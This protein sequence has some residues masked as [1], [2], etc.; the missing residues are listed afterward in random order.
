[1][2]IIDIS[3]NCKA[4]KKYP[5][6]INNYIFF[7]YTL[8][9]IIKIFLIGFTILVTAILLNIVA[10]LLNVATWYDFLQNKTVNSPIDFIWLFIAY[11]F[12]LGVAAYY[13]NK[14]LS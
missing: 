6:I 8:V 14:L 7:L 12:L 5:T 13:I 2:Q 3:E 11:P 9:M 1:M 4:T 10:K